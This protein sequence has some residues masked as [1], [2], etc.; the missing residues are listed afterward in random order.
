MNRI[1]M[2][3][4]NIKTYRLLNKDYIAEYRVKN[5]DVINDSKRKII[6]AEWTT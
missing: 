4:V 6:D 5:K 2:K 3:Y 1:E